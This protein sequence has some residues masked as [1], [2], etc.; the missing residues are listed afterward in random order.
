MDSYSPAEAGRTPALSP[1]L[2]STWK[3]TFREQAHTR[4]E[5]DEQPDEDQA[6][7]AALE[8]LLGR[9]TR[10]IEG[11][12]YLTPSEFEPHWISMQQLQ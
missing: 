11:L 4:F 5:G 12:R 3:S 10:P 1:N 6:R 2:L 9:A 8:Q 7:S